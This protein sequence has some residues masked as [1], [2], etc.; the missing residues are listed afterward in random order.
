MTKICTGGRLC[1][2]PYGPELVAE[3]NGGQGVH[4]GMVATA[5]T[6]CQCGTLYGHLRELRCWDLEVL[7]ATQ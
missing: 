4:G 7:V 3:R 6:Q 2:W 5:P 1:H